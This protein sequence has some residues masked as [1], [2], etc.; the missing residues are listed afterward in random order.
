M[1]AQKSVESLLR[2]S[3]EYFSDHLELLADMGLDFASSLDI[4]K[5]LRKGL[6]R[7][8]EHVNAAGG[9]LFLLE[10]GGKT[11]RCHACCGATEI[12]GLALKSDEGIVGRCVQN[13][14]G[15]IVRDVQDDPNF[16]KGAD[17]KT[18]FTTKSILC[19]PLSV[20]DEKIGAIELVNKADGDGLFEYSDLRLLQGLSASAAWLFSTPGWPKPWS[21]RNG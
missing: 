1:S 13:N 21:N 6:E 4:E 8:T 9:A 15:E 7:I 2:E 16:F 10:D 20:K 12:T 18:G 19:A 11:L 17:E 14:M 5:T 3:G